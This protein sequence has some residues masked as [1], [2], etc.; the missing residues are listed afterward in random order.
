MENEK[1]GNRFINRTG[2]RIGY[3][4]ITKLSSD[5]YIS[6][7]TGKKTL[8]WDFICD[9]GNEGNFITIKYLKLK[10]SK[11]KTSCG[12]NMGGVRDTLLLFQKGFSTCSRCNETKPIN[13]FSKN[14]NTSNGLQSTCKSCKSLIDKEYR[15][16]PRFRQRILDYKM[17]DYLKIRNDPEK[18]SECLK[19]NRETRDYALEYNRVQNDP[20]RKTK[21]TIRNLLLTSFKV[22]DIKKSSLCMRTEEIIGCSFEFFKEYI[23]SQFEGGMSWLNHGEWHLDHKVPLNKSETIEELVKLNHW[24]N[25][26][27]LWSYDNLSKGDVLLPE[28]KELYESLMRRDVNINNFNLGY[29]K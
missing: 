22:R 19:R 3:I 29:G 10:N 24:S 25:F 4:T 14:K 12:C 16:D 17:N 21:N 20:I 8:K 13:E 18:W 6:P 15:N 11:F 2:D 27:P 23:E 1:R 28:F 5:I 9:C 7:K 26:Q